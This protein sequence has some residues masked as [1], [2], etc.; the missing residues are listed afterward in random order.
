[1]PTGF[2]TATASTARLLLNDSKL[3]QRADE[4]CPV[5]RDQRGGVSQFWRRRCA[6]QVFGCMFKDWVRSSGLMK[7]LIMR[8]TPRTPLLSISIATLRF[9]LYYL[10][11]TNCI[12]TALT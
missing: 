4:T 6:R 7:A 12:L 1:M 10:A 9:T 2:C 11:L 8:R 3:S 5:L